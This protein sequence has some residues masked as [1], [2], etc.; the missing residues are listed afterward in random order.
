MGANRIQSE[1]DIERTHVGG[2]Q[3]EKNGC[4]EEKIKWGEEKGDSETKF[5][6]Q[7]NE[8]FQLKVEGKKQKK[9]K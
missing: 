6:D 2:K 7:G 5:S 9:K 1:I 4:M 8:R 3:S